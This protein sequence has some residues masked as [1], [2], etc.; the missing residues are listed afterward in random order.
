MIAGASGGNLPSFK[1][2]RPDDGGGRRGD[3]RRRCGK[4]V[5]DALTATVGDIR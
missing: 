2:F 1:M 3:A 5:Q 4:V